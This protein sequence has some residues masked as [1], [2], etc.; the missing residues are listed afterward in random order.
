MPRRR[1]TS[2]TR[3]NS[4][5]TQALEIAVRGGGHN[6]AGR[7]TIDGGLMIDLSPMQG[8]HV[9]ARH[10]RRRGPQ[11]GAHVERVQPRDAAPRP[12]HDRRGRR[13]APASRGLTL[14]GGLGWLMREAR[15]GARQPHARWSSSPADGRGRSRVERRRAPRPLLGRSAAVAATSASPPRS[16]TVCIQSGRIVARRPCLPTRFSGGQDVLRLLPRPVPR[17]RPTS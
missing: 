12:R 6:V 17:P 9:D 11:G 14:G 7:A 10:A 5:E 13:H 2:S 8:V 3:S 4:R 16:S 15:P 1:P